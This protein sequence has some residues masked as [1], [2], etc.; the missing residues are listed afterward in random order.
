MGSSIYLPVWPDVHVS[1]VL[2]SSRLLDLVILIRFMIDWKSLGL[3]A[4][5]VSERHIEVPFGLLMIPSLALLSITLFAT[6]K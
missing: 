6:S 2:W 4:R 1:R 5:N 3:G